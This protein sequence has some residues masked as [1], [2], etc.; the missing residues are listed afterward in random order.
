MASNRQATRAVLALG[1]AVTL[2]LGSAISAAAAIIGSVTPSEARPGDR[3]TL[4]VQGFA[5]QTQTVYLIS[6]SDFERQIAR[7]GRQV[8]NTAG[9]TALGCS[10]GAAKPAR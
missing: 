6:T 3:V 2:S 10:R 9:Q 4:T 5:S 1:G 8:C 7:F